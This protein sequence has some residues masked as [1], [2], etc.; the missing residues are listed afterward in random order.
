MKFLVIFY[1]VMKLRSFELLGNGSKLSAGN[2]FHKKLHLHPHLRIVDNLDNFPHRC[3]LFEPPTPMKF[4]WCREFDLFV[5][6]A[7]SM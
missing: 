1:E 6:F 2:Y 3:I 4:G 7:K 5:T